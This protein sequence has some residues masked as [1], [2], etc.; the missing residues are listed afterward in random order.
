MGKTLN[1]SGEEL[2]AL[3]HALT[4][5]L[6]AKVWIRTDPPP[7]AGGAWRDKHSALHKRAFRSILEK[8]VPK[9][10]AS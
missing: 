8:I 6:D 4:Y 9:A 1:L 7:R 3:E 2:C 5:A 10:T